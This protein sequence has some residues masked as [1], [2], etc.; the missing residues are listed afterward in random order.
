MSQT[1]EISELKRQ[2]EALKIKNEAATERA[3]CRYKDMVHANR[4]AERAEQTLRN[5]AWERQDDQLK[6]FRLY[7]SYK[8]E[9]KNLKLELAQAQQS[10]YS[11]AQLQELQ[12][13]ITRLEAEL[14]QQK[15][16]AARVQT[17]QSKAFKHM[18]AQY[19]ADKQR[20]KE[21]SEREYQKRLTE[22]AKQ[23]RD[24]FTRKSTVAIEKL[25]K[26]HES[27]LQENERL[28][29]Q[30]KQTQQMLEWH[31]GQ[32]QQHLAQRAGSQGARIP[33]GIHAG[34]PPPTQQS[35][36]QI[37]DKAR[38]R[39][40]LNST[41]CVGRVETRN[42]QNNANSDAGIPTPE[43]Q[44]GRVDNSAMTPKRK[45]PG[46]ARQPS[47]KPATPTRL[48]QRPTTS[49]SPIQSF[50]Q[51]QHQVQ[52]VLLQAQRTGNQQL[53]DQFVQRLNADRAKAGHSQLTPDQALPTFNRWIT[54]RASHQ[55]SAPMASHGDPQLSVQ[56]NVSMMQNQNQGHCQVG[57]QSPFL[58]MST[59][60][61]QQTLR[62][63]NTQSPL[64]N[65]ACGFGS[66]Q[67]MQLPQQYQQSPHG[68]SQNNLQSPAMSSHNFHSMPTLTAGY[69]TNLPAIPLKNPS[70]VQATP[71][72]MYSGIGEMNLAAQLSSQLRDRN[73]YPFSEDS[74]G[75][76]AQSVSS[77]QSQISGWASPAPN[78]EG[79]S[80]DESNVQTSFRDVS[81]QEPICNGFS[82]AA[83]KP[84]LLLCHPPGNEASSTAW[85]QQQASH[86]LPQQTA[87]PLELDPALLY[88]STVQGTD[89][90]FG[91]FN[92]GQTTRNDH[93]TFH[94]R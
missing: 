14:A 74:Q 42:V 91:I 48:Q 82:A 23:V 18:Q 70:Q 22:Q 28:K 30:L 15:E 39:R 44:Q 1:E 29:Q 94:Q 75:A 60:F 59:P 46:G 76:Q 20:S 61:D 2:N 64:S 27:T 16:A 24:E 25:T 19:E 78:Y 37:K 53:F 8:E 13:A 4:R 33:A 81:M 43:H 51:S 34:F 87:Q 69:N 54:Q 92:N 88:N 9:I 6:A 47:Q 68:T 21:Q 79:S 38:K 77:D 85:P 49:A 89:S 65:R 63:V 67:Q 12:T 11:H 72:E 10:G 56:R 62:S 52:A 73:M 80:Y 3:A 36:A 31:K 5:E 17:S 26:Q 66:A 35:P 7:S 32:T 41:G 55:P 50:Q 45:A 83:N 71:Q 57:L 58:P 84:E 86:N 40:R 93:S 90:N